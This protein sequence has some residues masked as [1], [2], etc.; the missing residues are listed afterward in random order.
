MSSTLQ[1][2]RMWIISADHQYSGKK[3]DR[4]KKET[5]SWWRWFDWRCSGL[6]Q[7]H[8]VWFF[9]SFENYLSRAA[10]HR[11]WWSVETLLFWLI[12]RI[13][14]GQA[15]A[16]VWRRRSPQS[17]KLP[18]TGCYERNVRNGWKNDSPLTCARR[19][20]IS[21][22]GPA[23]FLLPC[24]WRCHVCICVLWCLGYSRSIFQEYSL[25]GT[26]PVCLGSIFK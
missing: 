24:D 21:M 3:V 17:A 11:Q 7:V 4:K 5:R 8:S 10:C 15:T 6:L 22:F 26:C 16:A 12:L 1:Y 14:T 13:S 18:T 23:M 25:A 2:R 20:W 19:P 9:L